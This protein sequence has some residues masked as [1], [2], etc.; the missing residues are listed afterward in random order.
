MDK[1][2]RICQHFSLDLL[3]PGIHPT[4]LIKRNPRSFCACNC[5]RKQSAK[6]AP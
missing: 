3:L 2:Q 6:S 5:K 1:P 4:A